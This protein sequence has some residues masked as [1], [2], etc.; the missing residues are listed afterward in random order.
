MPPS[1]PR[2][3]RL[4][5]MQ[6]HILRMMESGGAESILTVINT[7]W[8]LYRDSGR[9]R[10][11]PE[12][13]EAI[14]GLSRLGFLK[15]HRWGESQPLPADEAVRWLTISTAVCWKEEGEYWLWI[16]ERYNGPGIEY[17]LT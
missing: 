2:K 7:L 16:D 17:V 5:P 1:H 3:L 12:A 9:E 15:P 10:F 6:G 11:I 13:E 4:S 14:Q 8:D